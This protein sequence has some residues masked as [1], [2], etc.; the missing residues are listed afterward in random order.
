MGAP[1]REI[2]QNDADR[3]FKLASR[4]GL[5]IPFFTSI[6]NNLCIG[7]FLILSSGYNFAAFI[8]KSSR[9]G[10]KARLRVDAYRE[11]V[12]NLIPRKPPLIY[13]WSVQL[14]HWQHVQLSN[15]F[16]VGRDNKQ[17]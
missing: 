12:S 4:T 7:T 9:R 17:P 8:T 15:L 16:H 2:I 13:G 11:S 10:E 3:F 6:T 5:G 1:R 14:R